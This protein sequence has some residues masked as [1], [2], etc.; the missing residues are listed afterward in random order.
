MITLIRQ[1]Y[2]YIKK[3]RL[4]RLNLHSTPWTFPDFTTR[5]GIEKAQRAAHIHP[6]LPHLLL[7]FELHWT[8]VTVNWKWGVRSW[9]HLSPSIL[10]TVLPQW[11]ELIGMQRG[12]S[13]SLPPAFSPCLSFCSAWNR[14]SDEKQRGPKCLWRQ[15]TCRNTHTCTHS[16]Y[17]WLA[18]PRPCN[19]YTNVHSVDNPRI[20]DFTQYLI[21][22]MLN[23]CCTELHLHA[24]PCYSSQ[25]QPTRRRRR[26]RI[27]K[28]S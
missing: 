11:A 27:R 4:A 21:E 6:V 14:H 28:T 10:G 9:D 22:H 24:V 16:E 18:G 25:F 13:L 20:L 7:L 3:S 19:A 2:Y 17:I 15:G 1:L 8:V 5:G 12:L 26:G 23:N